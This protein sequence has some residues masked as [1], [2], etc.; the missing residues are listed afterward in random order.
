MPNEIDLTGVIFSRLTVLNETKNRTADGNVIWLCK[1][2]CGILVEIS[3][4]SLRRGLT[5][6]CGC[7]KIDFLCQRQFKH[8]D[9]KK[10]IYR[11]WQAMK[12]R[13]EYKADVGYR[14]YGNKGVSICEEW[15]NYPTF[16][17]WALK[18]GYADNLVID[19][20]NSK[21]N[22]NPDNCRFITQS[23]NVKKMLR[24]HGII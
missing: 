9:S 18:N 21:E 10:R 14:W 6:S 23:K 13:C 15:S 2:K 22:Y 1:C 24:E 5:K 8:G 4:H 20:I 12:S 17:K 7:W 19:R 11:T 3:S 16:K